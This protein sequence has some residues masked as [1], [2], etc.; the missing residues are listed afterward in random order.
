MRGFPRDDPRR[1]T[2]KRALQ[3]L[4]VDNDSSAYCQ[5]CVSPDLGYGVGGAGDAGDAAEEAMDAGGDRALDWLKH[6]NCG[7]SRGTGRSS[8]PRLP[9]GGWAFQ[10]GNSHYPDLDDTAV[11]VWAMHPARRSARYASAAR[12]L[13]W[14]VGMQSRNG[15]FAAFDADNTHY[16]LNHIPF[17][18]HGALLDPPTSDVTARV[19]TALA[20]V[21]RPQELR[22]S[23]ARSLS[24]ATEQTADG[25]LVRP[26]GHQLHLWHLVGAG[27]VRSRRHRSR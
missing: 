16:N 21:G 15:G 6:G 4:L 17:A 5:P 25:W 13:D 18:D 12:A 26:L 22:R 10:F 14:L 19:V 9:G 3:K 7:M 23:N 1:V 11:I 27:R 8:R 24:C 20:R 2:A